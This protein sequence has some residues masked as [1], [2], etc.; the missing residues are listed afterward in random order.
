[1]AP[2]F[3]IV[4]KPNNWSKTIKKQVSGDTD[5]EKLR[6]EY[7]NTFHNFVDKKN[8]DILKHG[9]ANTDHWCDFRVG[10]AGFHYACILTVKNWIG[11][12]VY[13]GGDKPDRNKARYDLI[14]EKCKAQ[15]DAISSK[16]I[17]W[18]R[19]DD[20]KASLVNVK[21]EADMKDKADWPRQMEWMYNTMMELHKIVKPYYETIRG[22][23]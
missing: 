1:M 10:I 14:E 11:V 2:Q 19:L 7:W 20:K 4:A 21:F 16:K 3:D 9:N 18:K 22:I 15:I 13:F 5:T 12:Q 17:E 6:M 8:L 23:K